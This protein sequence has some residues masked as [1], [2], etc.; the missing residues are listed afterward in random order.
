MRGVGDCTLGAAV[1][2]LADQLAERVGIDPVAFRLRNQVR[3]G[4]ELH[5]PGGDDAIKG[6][7]E[8]YREG[9]SAADRASWPELFHLSSGDTHAILTRGADR[10]RFLER[11]NGWGAPSQVD[12]P[13]CRAV[14]VGTA[15]H[16]CGVEAEGNV[17]AIVR[18]NPDG[19]AKLHCSAGRQGQG[20]ET[21]QVQ[22]AAEV[23]GIPFDQIDIET[24]DTDSCPWSHGSIASN[25]MYRTGW[26]THA[27]AIDARRQLLAIAARE[28]FDPLNPDQLDVTDGFVHPEGQPDSN[29]RATVSGVLNRIRSDSLGQTSSI[30]GRPDGPMPPSTTFARH[31]AAH[32]VE[33]EVDR[34]TGQVKLLDYLATQDSGTI[35]NPQVVMNQVIGGAVCGLGLALYEALQFD[36]DTG[37]ILN[38]NLLDYKLLRIADFPCDVD[39]LF[40]ESWDPVGPFG[41]RGAG[42][43]PI[44]AAVSAVSQAVYN[45]IGT[46]V[47]IPMTPERIV[48]A[49]GGV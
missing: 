17:S 30:T 40:E 37:A 5:K 3:A 48:R 6:T 45:A 9:L 29:R 42:E 20:S 4:D 39:V 23:L 19:S 28:I 25:T 43:A 38:G 27:A 22:V 35:I 7:M 46:W 18:I 34:E 44:A 41:A 49:L 15:A 24:G 1:E 2:R 31:F 32:F 21:T 12:G 14:G 10:F 8:D 33:V 26:A 47:D 11:W 13:R 16:F 36:P